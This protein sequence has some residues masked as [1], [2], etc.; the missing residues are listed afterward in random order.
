[1]EGGEEEPGAEVVAGDV[2]GYAVP[3]FEGGALGGFERGTGLELFSLIRALYPRC[4][5]GRTSLK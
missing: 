4:N 1:M 2:L 3:Y 5:I